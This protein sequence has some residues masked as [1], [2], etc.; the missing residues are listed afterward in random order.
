MFNLEEFER[1]QVI[2]PLV[3]KLSKFLDKNKTAK[4]E[5]VIEQLDQLLKEQEHIISITYILSI[6][7]EHD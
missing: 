6:L 5:K 1:D 2:Y 4:A 3:E 7:A